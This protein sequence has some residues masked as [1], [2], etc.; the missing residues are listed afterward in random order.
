[1]VYEQTVANSSN[2][3]GT[4]AASRALVNAARR[5]DTTM[6]Q[7]APSTQVRTAWTTIREQLRQIASDYR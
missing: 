6:N 3:D 2:A 7:T 1:L 4:T 5:V